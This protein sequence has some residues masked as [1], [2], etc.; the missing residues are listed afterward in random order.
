MTRTD[1]GPWRIKAGC[2]NFTVDQANAHWNK[3]RPNGDPLG[4]ET[5]LIIAHMLAVAELRGWPEGGEE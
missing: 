1:T 3:T 4:D 5:R 2:R